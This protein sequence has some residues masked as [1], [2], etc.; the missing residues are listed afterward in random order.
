MEIIKARPIDLIEIVYLLRICSCENDSRG[1][2][3][4]KTSSDILSNTNFE[5]IYILK[6]N[7]LTIGL[8]SL[9]EQQNTGCCIHWTSDSEK[10]LY[11]E[12]LVVHPNWKKRGSGEQLLAF[13]E[14]YAG[15]HGFTSIRTDAHAE[16]NFSNE[17]YRRLN[18]KSAG[19]FL[20]PAQKV[21]FY[22]YE[23]CL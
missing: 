20:S 3:L 12:S 14:E 4:Q 6:D 22:C 7:S 8:V 18:F 15:S 11:I 2:L 17:L 1:Q 19:E 10:P 13:I 9:L 23:K 16:N 5:H 21:P